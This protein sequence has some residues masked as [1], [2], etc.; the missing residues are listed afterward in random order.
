M[1]GPQTSLTGHFVMRVE[2]DLRP[3]GSALSRTVTY[4]GV[5]TRQVW[6]PS[7]V[8]KFKTK[9]S[10]T[11]G[12]LYDALYIHKGAPYRVVTIT[13]TDDTE[14]D[15]DLRAQSATGFHEMVYMF[16]DSSIQRD[17]SARTVEELIAALAYQRACE[18]IEPIIVWED[19]E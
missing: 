18:Y 4:N 11:V 8:R 3:L 15:I 7:T 2:C 9:F 6:S 14:P 1:T 12:E 5:T 13:R 17:S 19:A 16:T 10:D